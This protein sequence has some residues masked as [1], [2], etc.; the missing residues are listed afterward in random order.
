ME[1]ITAYKAKETSEFES[2]DSIEINLKELAPLI[3]KSLKVIETSKEIL[4][5]PFTLKLQA[6]SHTEVLADREN[7]AVDGFDFDFIEI[8]SDEVSFVFFDVEG[9]DVSYNLEITNVNLEALN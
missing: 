1:T 5:E 8:N 9:S 6:H 7:D 2:P 4:E 3:K